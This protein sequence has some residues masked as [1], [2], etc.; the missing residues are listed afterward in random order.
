MIRNS[1]IEAKNIHSG[2]VKGLGRSAFQPNLVATGASNSEVNHI[3]LRT[4]YSI[5]YLLLLDCA[6]G[7]EC[8]R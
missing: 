6:M 1:M 8:D 4:I 3:Y 7:F 5:L 2:P